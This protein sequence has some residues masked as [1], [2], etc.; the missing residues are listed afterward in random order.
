MLPG[1][2]GTWAGVVERKPHFID[3]MLRNS[4][5]VSAYRFFGQSSVD[6]AYGDPGGGGTSGVGGAGCN[7]MFTVQR[8]TMYRS[9]T[10]R[11]RK[12]M[13][14]DSMKGITRAVFDLD[15][16]LDPGAGLNLPADN[17][18]LFLRVQEFRVA[19]NNWATYNVGLGGGDE[20]QLGPIYI[21]PVTEFWGLSEPTLTLAG[22]APDGT[23]CTV[24]LAPVFNEKWHDGAPLMNPLYL[25]FPRPLTAITVRNDEAAGGDPLL[26]SMGVGMPMANI[27]PQAELSLFTGASKEMILAGSGGPVAF[28]LYSSM[29]V[30]P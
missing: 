8:G 17:G 12:W 19:L 5:D 6:G 27:P 21:V 26:L 2:M 16:F 11:Q 23:D 28:S 1:P 24:G 13:I 18:Y 15:D 4:P 14:E 30:N 20:P 3:M 9:R 25:V 22:T 29:L 10:I 7:L